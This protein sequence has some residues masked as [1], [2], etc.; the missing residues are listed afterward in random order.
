MDDFDMG[1]DLR[2]GYEGNED[3]AVLAHCLSL[4][5][6]DPLAR[7]RDGMLPWAVEF[8]VG[9]GTTLNMIADVLPVLGFDS[10]M[11][12]PEDWR[13]NHRK[14]HFALPHSIHADSI[15]GATIVPGWFADTVP[16]YDWPNDVA[17]V[18]YDADLY[19]STLLALTEGPQP[20]PGTILV[21]DEFFGYDDDFA[22]TMPGEQQAWWEY[23]SETDITWDVIG[24]G[25]EQWA[26]RVR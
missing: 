26:V 2:V 22:G 8:G 19:S 3:H 16:G 10:F 1:P 12:L 13:P 15:P 25:R 18:H 9:T 5:N 20:D 11:G 7:S 21:F 4:I 17:L 24:H 23:A 6:A 14:G